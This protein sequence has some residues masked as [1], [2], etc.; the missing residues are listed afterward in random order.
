MHIGHIT[1]STQCTDTSGITHLVVQY[2]AT[3]GG[4]GD[5]GDPTDEVSHPVTTLHLGISREGPD[6]AVD[7]VPGNILLQL[8]ILNRQNNPKSSLD[9]NLLL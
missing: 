4:E 1:C 3:G 7:Q 2:G 5:G 9:I 8:V 6:Q